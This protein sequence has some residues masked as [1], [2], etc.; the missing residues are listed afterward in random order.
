MRFARKSQ[1][2]LRVQKIRKII[3]APISRPTNR[4]IRCPRVS[5]IIPP[6]R[7]TTSVNK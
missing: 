1:G 5:P 6:K 4:N 2:L 7:V 3:I